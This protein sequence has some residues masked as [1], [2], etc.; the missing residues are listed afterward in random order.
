MSCATDVLKYENI[1]ENIGIMYG[2]ELL[3]ADW[4]TFRNIELTDIILLQISDYCLKKVSEKYLEQIK[5]SHTQA[6]IERYK[7]YRDITYEDYLEYTS[8]LCQIH[9]YETTNFLEWSQK[10]HCDIKIWYNRYENG[11]KDKV[12]KYLLNTIITC[13]QEYI[14]KLPGYAKFRKACKRKSLARL[15]YAIHIVDNYAV[16]HCLIFALMHVSLRKDTET[17]CR[18]L[19]LHFLTQYKSIQYNKTNLTTLHHSALTIHVLSENYTAIAALR[20]SDKE[21]LETTEDI[22][23]VE[24]GYFNFVIQKSY[25]SL[26]TYLFVCTKMNFMNVDF[27]CKLVEPDSI[28]LYWCPDFTERIRKQVRIMFVLLFEKKIICD[29]NI[30]CNIVEHFQ[31]TNLDQL[32]NSFEIQANLEIDLANVCDI[33]QEAFTNNILIDNSFLI[34]ILSEGDREKCK[35]LEKIQRNLQFDLLLDNFKSKFSV[36][37]KAF[38]SRYYSHELKTYVRLGNATYFSKLKCFAGIFERCISNNYKCQLITLRGINAPHQV[39]TYYAML[40]S[41]QSMQELICLCQFIDDLWLKLSGNLIVDPTRFSM[42]ACLKRQAEYDQSLAKG[43]KPRI[44]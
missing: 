35:I 28:A 17:E 33:L 38:E 24:F 14:I 7:Y 39:L 40:Y 6:F 22:L 21:Y 16:Y 31:I 10:I 11:R 36:C 9:R 30:I 29:K 2:A 37:S 44:T 43:K 26:M 3:N 18:W 42:P 19:V 20:F 5:N 23:A 4:I 1:F 41:L 8:N 27:L 32:E 12:Y 34:T 15:L 13:L 25:E